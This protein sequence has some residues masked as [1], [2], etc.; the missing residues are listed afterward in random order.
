MQEKIRRL[1]VITTDIL[2]IFCSFVLSLKI[3]FGSSIN[4]NTNSLMLNY[5]FFTVM[6]MVIFYMKGIYNIRIFNKPKTHFYGILSSVTVGVLVFALVQFFTKSFFAVQSRLVIVLLGFFQLVLFS[7]VRVFVVPKFLNFLYSANVLKR[8]NML[9]ISKKTDKYDEIIK[10]F[11]R[12]RFLG[13]QPMNGFKTREEFEKLIREDN[14]REILLDSSSENFSDL[15]EEIEDYSRLGRELT[16]KSKLLK[17]L[18]DSFPGMWGEIE[19]DH[20]ILF[21]NKEKPLVKK[22]LTRIIDIIIAGVS[23]IILLPL[24]LG[25]GLLIKLTS[26]G[27]VFFKQRRMGYKGREFTFY[28]FRSMRGKDDSQDRAKQFKKYVEDKHS[29]NINGKKVVKVV[30]E[31]RITFIG[32]IIRKLSIDELPQLINVLKGEMS[33]VGP[34]PSLP[35]EVELYKQWHKA[36]FDVKPGLTGIWQVYGRSSSHFNVAMFMDYYYVQNSSMHLDINLILKTFPVIFGGI[37]GY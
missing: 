5:I 2:I 4:L 35:Y 10:F 28:K 11:D 9:V 30:D 22:I 29:M 37:G 32:K 14:I 7:T 34:R 18:P 12:N 27:P 19:K 20:L 8:K 3:R 16:I 21:Q 24:F 17:D 36:R 1:I 15:G 23:L 26:K 6:L 13:L 31:N 33:L 25:V